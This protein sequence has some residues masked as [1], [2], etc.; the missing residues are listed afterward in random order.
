MTAIH[1]SIFFS[2]NH[3]SK[4]RRNNFVQFHNSMLIYNIYNPSRLFYIYSSTSMMAENM[5]FEGLSIFAAKF[6]LFQPSTK[7]NQKQWSRV[8]AEWMSWKS[9]GLK[10]LAFRNLQ[11]RGCFAHRSQGNLK[12]SDVRLTMQPSVWRLDWSPEAALQNTCNQKLPQTEDAGCNH[13]NLGPILMSNFGR[14]YHIFVL[15]LRTQIWDL[16]CP[17]IQVS[18]SPARKKTEHID[19]ACYMCRNHYRFF[20]ETDRCKILVSFLYTTFIVC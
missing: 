5:H 15:P 11:E 17:K 14:I 20:I 12:A 9:C 8:K 18:L 1:N 3:R 6:S 2:I 10:F 4:P 16:L 19:C 13:K 7:A